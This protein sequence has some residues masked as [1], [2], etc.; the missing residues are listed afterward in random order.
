MLNI[1]YFIIL[2]LYAVN[3]TTP[4]PSLIIFS[5]SLLFFIFA[6]YK[7]KKS[8]TSKVTALLQILCYSVPISWRSIFGGDYSQLPVSWFHLIGAYIIIHLIIIKKDIILK[9]NL[10]GLCIVVS[11]ISVFS[12]VPLL[13]TNP[14]YLSQGLS[15]FIILTFHHLLILAAIIKGNIISQENI[16][17]IEKTYVL[18]GAITS[19]GIITQYLLFRSGLAIGLLDN[20]QNRQSFR[21][22]FGDV[23]H[24]SL[25]LATTTFLAL[26]LVTSKVKVSRSLM[27]L[28]IFLTLAGSAISSARTGLVIFVVF[29][30]LFILFSN[31]SISKKIIYIIFCTIGLFVAISF[32]QQVRPQDGI[33]LAIFD[34]SGRTIGYNIA[35]GYFLQKPFL[36]Y[37][38]SIDYISAILQTPIP[39]LS[40]LQYLIHGGF[41]Y[42][43][44]IFAILLYAAYFAKRHHMRVAWLIPMVLIGTC[45]I[46]DIFSTRY[47]TILIVLVFI[48]KVSCDENVKMSV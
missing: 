12:L 31:I 27:F 21:F 10:A 42:A 13:L 46:P 8:S 7:F 15:Q 35:V 47:I 2:I 43:I 16:I 30:V 25:Y 39:H 28:Y 4:F 41:L 32:M 26:L 14:E 29:F 11:L 40:F 38:F 44:M 20:Y 18:V 5:C 37:G 33:F 22:L 45:L 1:F 36:G 48:S 23:S 19:L 24:A 3:I 34:S 9:K 6:F 17:K